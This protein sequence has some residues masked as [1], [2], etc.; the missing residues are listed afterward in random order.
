MDRCTK[1]LALG[2]LLFS[3]SAGAASQPQPTSL[4]Q[5][6]VIFVHPDGTALNSW[7]IARMYWTGPDG[8]LNW[9]RMPFMAAYRGHMF[10]SLAGTSNGGATTHAFGYKVEAGGSFGRDGNG[11]NARPIRSLSGYPGSLMREAASRGLAVGVVNDGHLG[12]PGTGAFLAEVE[13]RSNWDAISLQMLRGRPGHQ[14]PAPHVLLGGGEESFLPQGVE[15]VHGPGRRQD[16]RNLVKEAEELGYL[17]LRTRT[18][19]EQLMERLRRESTFAPKV[20]GLFARFHTFNDANEE[21]LLADQMV[22]PSVD[23]WAKTSQL[24]LFGGK[25]NTPS[26]NP[27]TFAEMMEMATLILDRVAQQRRTRFFLVAEPE[28]CDNF[29]NAGNAIG[30]LVAMRRADDGLGVVLDFIRRRPQTLLV[31]AADSDANGMQ[32]VAIRTAS[33]ASIPNVT[34]TPGNPAHGRPEIALPLDGLYGRDSRAFL[35]APDQF[36]RTMAFG[37]AWAADADVSGGILSRAAGIN[38][39]LLQT[40]FSQRFDNIDVYRMM[41]GTLFGRL[42]PYPQG[43]VAPD[44]PKPGNPTVPANR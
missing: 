9:D 42:L 3:L 13:N 22:N 32:A 21:R 7:H 2:T 24:I 15:G 23:Q 16:G 41:H 6:N 17:V 37:V 39:N 26:F 5:G 10:D 44:A 8:T 27:P 40:T 20:L 1:I 11:A 14:D 28:S 31:T 43:Q 4:R 12:E 19:F 25:P 30:K 35:A 18:D 29:G 38:A 34:T 36:G 33:G